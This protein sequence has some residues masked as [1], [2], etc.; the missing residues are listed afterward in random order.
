MFM[1]Q[2]SNTVCYC[3]GGRLVTHISNN[4]KEPYQYIDILTSTT[5]P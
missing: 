1:L 5:Y 4:I 2:P 3:D